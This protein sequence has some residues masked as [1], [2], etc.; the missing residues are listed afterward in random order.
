MR[1]LV[2]IIALALG[3]AAT[4]ASAQPA[5]GPYKVLQTVKAGGDGGFDY[6]YA[7]AAN[8]RLYVPRSGAGARITVFDLD[9][10][11]PAGAIANTSGH[12]AAVDPKAGHGF[13][14]SK[15]VAMWDAKTLA[16][17]KTIEVQGNPDGILGDPAG[18][19]IY[20][21]SH[22]APH[23]TAIDAV[24]GSVVGTVDIGGAPEQAV[25]DGAGRLYVDV[26]DKDQIA[27]VD[28]KAMTLVKSYGLQGRC[29]TPAGLALDAKT[30]VLFV[31]C[32]TPAVM[33][34]VNAD[35]GQILAVLPI[36]VGVDGAA[37]NPATA[38]AFASTGDGILTVIKE[39]SPTSFVVEQSVQTK[40]GAKT[41]TL[42]AKTGHVLLIAAEYGPPPA[43]APAA[44]PG[45]PR[46]GPMVPGSFTILV[47]GR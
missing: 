32:R 11:A 28:A 3:A 4:A 36:G 47:V 20:I 15:P 41:L 17:I 46:R 2:T 14:S 40:A 19:R 26:E 16:P 8:R 29:G 13:S 1:R 34:M 33:A 18:Q 9:T 21:L 42:D 39:T 38:E 44:R 24:D 35:S 6:V 27:V 12:G 43:D 22:A 7:D 45:R 10:L 5:T 30:H 37:F 23:V 31:A 25:S